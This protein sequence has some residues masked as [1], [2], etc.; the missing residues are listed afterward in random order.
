[1]MGIEVDLRDVFPDPVK[2]LLT[3]GI[4]SFDC[5]GSVSVL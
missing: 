4:G 2:D 1:M 3:H 5:N